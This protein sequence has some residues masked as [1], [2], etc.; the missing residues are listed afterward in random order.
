VPTRRRQ[1]PLVR[2]DDTVLELAALMAQQ[3]SP[4][5]VVVDDGHV[6]GVVTAARLLALGRGAV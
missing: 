1:L 3:H 4:E 5:V 6:V 2:A